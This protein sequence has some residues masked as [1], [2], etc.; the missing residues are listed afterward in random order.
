KDS[1]RE[2]LNA[3]VTAFAAHVAAHKK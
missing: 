1:L 2:V 3:Y